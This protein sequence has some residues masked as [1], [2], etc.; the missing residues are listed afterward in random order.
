[1]WPDR[2]S[3]PERLAIEY[4]LRYV[5]NVLIYSGEATLPFFIFESIM[6]RVVS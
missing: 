2:V 1:M 4:R 6:I 5:A 3:N